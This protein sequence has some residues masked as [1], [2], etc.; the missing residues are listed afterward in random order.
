MGWKSARAAALAAWLLLPAASATALT[1]T[2][3]APVS[4]TRLVVDEAA[5]PTVHVEGTASSGASVDVVCVSQQSGEPG[6]TVVPIA[7]GVPVDMHAFATDVTWP[8]DPGLCEVYAVAP[9]T[10]P[11][12]G[13]DLNGLEGSLVYEAATDSSSAEGKVYDYDTFM[14]GAGGAYAVGSFGACPVSFGELVQG[15]D[16]RASIFDC[17]GYL[18]ATDPTSD[19]DAPSLTVDG[20]PAYTTFMIGDDDALSVLPGWSGLT[21]AVS[22]DA[23]A[24]HVASHE[25]TYR[26]ADA[27]CAAFAS[28]GLGVDVD[29]RLSRDG[30]VLVQQLRVAS[31]D[32]KRH[33][34]SAVLNQTTAD[35]RQ[36]RFPGAGGFQDYAI[37]AAPSVIAPAVATIR[38]RVASGTPDPDITTGFGAITYAVRPSAEVFWDAGD[39]FTQ[40]YPA[41]VVP[42]GRAIRFEFVY[43]MAAGSADLNAQAG[44]AEA[45][46]AGPPSISVTSAGAA[47]SPAYTLTGSVTAPE[48]LSALIVNDQPVTAAPDGAFAVPVSL[49]EGANTFTIRASDELGRI[50]TNVFTV[51]LTTPAG[52]G[53]PPPPPHPPPPPPSVVFDAAGK[54]VLMRRVLSTGLTATCPGLGPDC[55]V[56]A[57]VRAAGHATRTVLTLEPDATAA[58]KVTLTKPAAKQLKRRHRLKVALVLTGTR[59]GA[60]TTTTKKT[61]VLKTK[62]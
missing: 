62:R 33:V 43:S 21:Y 60:G 55:T 27:S 57:R 61:V 17:N 22:D 24:F 36:W 28:T 51:A 41:R 44:A 59:D 35:A 31:E 12:A 45:S 5:P 18:E 25:Q 8:A 56:S 3:A 48:R 19:A 38:N 34:L 47:G 6:L 42:A 58:I 20:Q 30:R 54:P 26:C 53:R 9:G 49:G 52:D 46:V 29:E 39:A 7:A 4:G 40:R 10:V 15:H 2:I 16:E 1:T 37:G 32:G 50:A 13:N 14:D 11:T 23:G